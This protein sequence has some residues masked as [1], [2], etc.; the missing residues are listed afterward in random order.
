M[1]FDDLLHVRN[2]DTYADFFLP[3]LETTTSLLDL[4]CGDGALTVSLAAYAGR[5]TAVDFAATEF[6]AAQDYVA[7]HGIRNLVFAADDATAL[8]FGDDS[9][10]ACFCHSMLESVADPAAVL[11]EVR[12][13]LCPGGYVGVASTEYGGLILAGPEAELLLRSNRVREQVWLRHDA[14][15]FLGRELRRLL[16]EADFDDVRATTKALSYGTAARVREFGE[17]RAEEC[18]DAE[19]ADVAVSAG[20]VS[21]EELETMARA[22]SAWG[23]SS[24]SYAAFTWC[25]AVGRKPLASQASQSR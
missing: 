1:A 22:W 2:A 13:V 8:S 6:A 4:G 21:A 18:A 10:D 25:R 12:R 9:F 3:H 14:N 24:A 11:H 16:V 23:E 15:P 20:V 17:G 19:Y 5:V 7:S